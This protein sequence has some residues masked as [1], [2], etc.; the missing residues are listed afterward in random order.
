[1]TVSPL[2]AAKAI[3]V[4]DRSAD[5]AEAVSEAMPRERIVGVSNLAAASTAVAEQ[6]P[7]AVIVAGPSLASSAGINRLQQLHSATP[8]SAL[9]LAFGKEPAGSMRDVIRAGAC[10]LLHEEFDTPDLVPVLTRALHLGEG[11]A[12]PRPD[13][14]PVGAGRRLGRVVTVASAT[15]GCGKTF[16]ATNLAWFLNHH[17]RERACI[18]DLDLQ[19][20]EVSTAL[21]LRPRFTITDALGHADTDDLVEHLDEYLVQHESGVW[22]LAAPRTPEEADRIQPSDVTRIIEAVRRKFD[23][24]VVDTPSALTEIVLTAFDASERLYVMATLDLPS[25]RNLSVFLTTLEKLKVP[26]DDMRLILNKAESDVGLDVLEVEQLFPQGFSATLPYAKE[27]HR[28]INLGTP[29]LASAPT[30]PVS[31]AMVGGLVELLPEAR[32]DEIAEQAAAV[33][34]HVKARKLGFRLFRSASAK[35]AV[36]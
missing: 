8:R 19:F 22:V 33:V 17:T 5:L 18:V 21:R 7:F 32:R 24:V 34:T 3:L 27:V 31:K 9:V 25:I 30:A 12:A 2:S 20:G 26:A 11:A 6:G 4:F 28:S 36:A 35:E 29:V 1:M 15:G 10:D 23:W 16:M 13:A 14:T